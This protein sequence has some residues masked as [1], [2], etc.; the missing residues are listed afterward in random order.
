[1]T[2]GITLSEPVISPFGERYYQEINGLAFDKLTSDV[3]FNTHYSDLLDSEEH[4]FIVVGTDSGLLYSYLKEQEF[5]KSVKFIFIDFDEVIQGAKVIDTDELWEGNFRLVSAGFKFGRIKHDYQTYVIRR[6]ITLIKSLAV[7]DSK[8]GSP[9]F[10]LWEDCE[11]AFNGF[12]RSEFNSLSTKV[13]EEERIYNAADNMIP[14]RVL[15]NSLANRDVV[16]LGGGPTLDDAIEWLRENQNKVIIFAAARIAKR[17]AKEDITPDFF[18][19]VD[20]FDWSFDN[21]KSILAFDESSI[22]IHSFHAQHKIVSQWNGLSAYSGSRYG[23]KTDGLVNIDT[24][25]PTVTNSA[26]HLACSF[27]ARRV[28]LAGIDFCFARGLSHESGSDEA[29]LSDVYG[30]QAKA[31]LE[32]NEGNMTESSDDFYSAFHAMQE[33]IKIYISNMNCEFYSL[34]LHSAKMNNVQYI[35]CE[36]IELDNEDKTNLVLSL[37]DKL[38]VSIEEHYSFSKETVKELKEQL[39][40]FSKLKKLA[41]D[42]ESVSGK[43]YDKK[44]MEPKTKAMTR[45]QKLRKKVDTIIGDDG[46][47]LMSYQAAFFHDSFKPVEDELAMEKDEIVEQLTSYFN[48][49]SKVSDHFITMLETGIERAQLRRDELDSKVM[50]SQLYDRWKENHEFGRAVQWNSWHDMTLTDDEQKVLD[51]ALNDFKDEFEKQDHNYISRVKKRISNVATLLGR[52]NHAF[53]NH[54]IA[55][56]A[57]L[58]EHTEGLGTESE[59]NKASFLMYLKGMHAELTEDIP[60][61]IMFYQEVEMPA[62]KQLALKKMLN[63]T[64]SDNNYEG[65]LAVLEQLCAFSLDYM[66]PYADLLALL[67]NKEAAAQILEMYL[68]QKPDSSNVQ[69]KYAQILIEL[70]QLERAE[71]VLNSILEHDMNNKMAQVLKAKLALH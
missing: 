59:F 66:V 71:P 42:G 37:R 36:N 31:K 5:N 45:V 17:L 19:T 9:Y 16:V 3:V 63:L 23:W 8:P 54:D 52:G 14:A 41:D 48:G 24:P 11:V 40:R 33:A 44:T 58:I 60:S 39:Q 51:Q 50:P 4:L 20:P 15:G 70:N 6:K 43:L 18:V 25:G 35:P 28:F 55:E 53:D 47:M 57:G 32:D 29:K 10:Q 61:A 1:M 22:L 62:L 68:S 34:G 69:I 12:R 30:Y 21:S 38:D 26:L 65:S 49:V 56:L 13:F 2:H 64:M 67:G 46:D 27:G 7:L